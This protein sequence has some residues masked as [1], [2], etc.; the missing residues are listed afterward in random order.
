MSGSV[1]VTASASDDNGV[2]QVQFFVD[3]NSIGVDTTAPYSA[4]W[5]TTTYSDGSHTVSAT[6]TDT[7]GQNGS[8]SVGVTVQNTVPSGTIHVS[9]ID[10]S[11]TKQGPNYKIATQVT[12]VDENGLPVSGATVNLSI[13]IPGGGTATGSG[14]TGTNGT[15]TFNY[16]AGRTT[17][18]YV[19][20][21][22][23][24]SHSSFT[25]NSGANIVNSASLQ[26]P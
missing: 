10:M 19:A 12:I 21:V 14:T 5:D 7:I 4:S 16:N 20:T 1:N 23:N 6:A 3:G 9:A 8:N 15:V 11:Y 17:G 24:V 26:V 22:T 13:D 18:T 25:Y 2:T